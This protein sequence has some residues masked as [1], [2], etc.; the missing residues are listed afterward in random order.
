MP[1]SAAMPDDVRL[2]HYCLTQLRGHQSGTP[3]TLYLHNCG[4]ALRFLQVHLEQCYA[5]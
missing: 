2:L 3:L 4:T 1:V 5:G